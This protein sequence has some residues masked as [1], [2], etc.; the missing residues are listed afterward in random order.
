[1]LLE[2]PKSSL[3]P[4]TS[5]SDRKG[6]MDP[7]AEVS[8]T[9]RGTPRHPVTSLGVEGPTG[10]DSRLPAL[11][12]FTSPTSG[13]PLSFL[14]LYS[15]LSDSRHVRDRCGDGY[16]SPKEKFLNISPFLFP[17]S[18]EVNPSLEPDVQD[19]GGIHCL[20]QYP[21]AQRKTYEVLRRDPHSE[22]RV[23]LEGEIPDSDRS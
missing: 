10:G 23:S 1:M 17:F 15:S 5:L 4:K 9:G 7:T 12:V 20:R 11:R 22:V 16:D 14:L 18:G 6:C 8:V 3:A 2:S 13:C 21:T 19:T